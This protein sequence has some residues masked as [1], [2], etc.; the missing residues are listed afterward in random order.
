MSRK[1]HCKIGETELVKFLIETG[2][3]N[4]TLL[5]DNE[6]ALINFAQRICKQLPNCTYRATPTYSPQSK[7]EVERRHQLL[8]SQH[9]TQSD[10]TERYKLT[11]FTILCP[12]FTWMIKRS[13]FL[14]N[15]YLLHDD[16][17]TSYSSDGLRSTTRHYVY[18]VKLSCTNYHNDYQTQVQ[19]GNKDFGFED[20]L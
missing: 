5:I 3:A 19:L 15:R 9:K 13:R 7:S 12:R 8:L 10:L 16:G 6:P 1:G 11:T 2:R 14:L 17:L 20:A 4:S 18:S